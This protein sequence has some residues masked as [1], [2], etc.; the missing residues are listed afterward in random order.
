MNSKSTPDYPKLTV[1]VIG[2]GYVGLPLLRGFVNAGVNCLGLDVD[3]AKVAQLKK[4]K[5]YIEHIPDED[6]AAMIRSGLFEPS[7]QFSKLAQADAILIT[8]P[9]PLDKMRQPD[10]TFVEKSCETIAKTLRKGQ[11]I[12]LESTTYPGTTRDVMVPILESISGLTAGK[13]FFVAYSPEREDP[14]REDFT[15]N[16]IP[17][18]IGGLNEE[19]LRRA[20]GVYQLLIEKLV[21]VAS[22]EV[23]EA[24]KILENTY[25]SVNIAMVNELKMLFDRMGI[26][27]WEVIRA[28]ATKPFGFSPFYPGPGL[29]G[30]CIPIDPFYLSWKAK[31]YDQPTRFIELAGE[32]NAAMPE[33]VVHKIMLALNE[34][35]AKALKKSKL[36]LVG[37]AYKPNVD[38]CRE[39]PTFKI[40]ELLEQHGAKID[41]H[42]PHVLEV[43]PTR[44]HSEY[45]GK[46][47]KKITAANVAKY[48]AVI[49]LTHHT[50]IDYELVAKNAE[51]VIDTRNAMSKIRSRKNIV[52]A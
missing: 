36:L 33:W 45:A 9:T 47:S 21:P 12:V 44:E 43:P 38:D 48:D 41:Y 13:D 22:C 19:S 49:I 23:A 5:S 4:K 2:L 50:N 10:L 32:V 15:T 28:A 17:K 3:D 24:S 6:I 46:K 7:T 51:L 18:V 30:H 31:E 39:S 27:V 11:V 25:R 14:G 8:V 26:D 16:T 52:K 37:L 40:W 20:V 34:R 29:G 42:D 35:S 1:A